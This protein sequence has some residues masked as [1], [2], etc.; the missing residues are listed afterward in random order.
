MKW[1]PAAHP[2]HSVIIT[3]HAYLFRDGTTL[4]VGDGTSIPSA[5]DGEAIWNKLVKKYSNI[6]LVMGGHDVSDRIMMTQ[7]TGDNG[8]TVT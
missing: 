3:T 6:I 5:N 1:L 2:G 4:S 7:S 8:N